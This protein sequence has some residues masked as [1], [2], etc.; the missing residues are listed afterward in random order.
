MLDVNRPALL[1]SYA[2]IRTAISI[3]EGE[4]SAQEK[5]TKRFKEKDEE[6]TDRQK[7]AQIDAISLAG[8]EAAV[9]ESNRILAA[10]VEE[11]KEATP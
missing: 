5:E 7:A 8:I 4:I 9:A 3:S 2:G 11:P 1:R 6:L 10:T